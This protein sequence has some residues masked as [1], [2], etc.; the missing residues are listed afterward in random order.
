MTDEPKLLLK[1]AGFTV[2]DIP[3]GHICCGSAGTYNI[4][5]PEMAGR[6]KERKVANIKKAKPDIVA[7]GNIGCIT[8]LASGM[9]YPIAHTAELLD[10]AYGG[11]VPP[12]LE[13]MS[14]FVTDVPGPR[15]TAED[16]IRA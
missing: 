6:L 5:Q 13:R 2:V 14:G 11:P 3:E 15:R 10:W 16:Y 4:L 7:A 9:D 1:R 8:Q 12:G